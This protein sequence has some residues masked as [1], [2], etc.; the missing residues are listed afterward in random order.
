MRA[1]EILQSATILLGAQGASS[2]TSGR[3]G[4]CGGCMAAEHL[5]L[6]YTLMPDE[7]G[8]R[9]GAHRLF[10]KRVIFNLATI[11][12]TTSAPKQ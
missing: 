12:P 2:S 3:R 5:A 10:R 8:I 11:M 1:H 6:M 4:I 9:K 7:F